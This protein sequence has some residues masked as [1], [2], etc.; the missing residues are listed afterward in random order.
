MQASVHNLP[1][2]RCTAEPEH[3][4]HWRRQVR[5]AVQKEKEKREGK[6]KKEREHID[7]Y[8]MNAKK[9]Q[10]IVYTKQSVSS[11]RYDCMFV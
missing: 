10:G 8:K 5:Q 9:S 11:R 6:R 2:T 4:R 3:H 7:H 1:K